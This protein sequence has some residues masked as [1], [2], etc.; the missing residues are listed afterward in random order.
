MDVTLEKDDNR[1]PTF[2]CISG[3]SQGQKLSIIQAV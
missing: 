1:V 3:Y 2:F